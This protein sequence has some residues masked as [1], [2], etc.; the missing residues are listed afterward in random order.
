MSNQN[1]ENNKSFWGKTKDVASNC[2]KHPIAVLMALVA[3]GLA[4]RS[5]KIVPAQSYGVRITLGQMKNDMLK[6]GFYLKYPVYDSIEIFSNNTVIVESEVGSIATSTNS[7]ELN[8]SDRNPISARLRTHYRINPKVGSI[9]LKLPELL[10]DSNNGEKAFQ[11]FENQSFN[12]VVGSRPAADTLA[13]PKGFLEA[14]LDNLK[15]RL[16]QNNM[17]IEVDVVELKSFHTDLNKP[18]QYRIKSDGKVEEMAGPAAVSVSHGGVQTD[19]GN[20]VAVPGRPGEGKA[21]MSIRPKAVETP[22][23]H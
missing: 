13:D 6:P 23:Q 22:E 17:P 1:Y 21:T 9:A 3:V 15:W 5:Y 7:G 11:E 10:G 18:I 4:A 8:S 2:A 12:A 14:F 16:A 19:A 20:V